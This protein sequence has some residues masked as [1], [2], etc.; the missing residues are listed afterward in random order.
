[1]HGGGRLERYGQCS[2]GAADL[3]GAQ[4]IEACRAVDDLPQA[5][6]AVD[7][8]LWDRAGRRAG[9]PIAELLTDEPGE[10]GE[11]QRDDR[12]DRPRGRGRAG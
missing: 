6:A 10:R 8:A 1:M 5:L 12:G 4:M 11:R 3:T 9:K 2:R 7:M